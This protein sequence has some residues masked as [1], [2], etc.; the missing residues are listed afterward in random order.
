MDKSQITKHR[1][2]LGDSDNDFV[3]RTSSHHRHRHQ[4]RSDQRSPNQTVSRAS[5]QPRRDSRRERSLSPYSKR[6]ALTQAM[7]M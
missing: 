1:R 4:R 2:S 6:L 5:L 7:N 3:D